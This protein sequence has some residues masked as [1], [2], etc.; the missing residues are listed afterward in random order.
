MDYRPAEDV[1]TI[2]ETLDH[3]YGLTRT[4]MHAPES[5]V[6]TYPNYEMTFEELRKQTLENIALTSRLLKEGKEGDM[7]NYKMIFQRQGGNVEY[8]FWNMINGPIADAI[9]HTG[10]VVSFRRAAGNPIPK[11][12]RMLTGSAPE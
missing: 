8:P 11:G 5:K 6:N 12:V 4:I 10:Q 9:Y 2:R 1:R 7:D 3:I